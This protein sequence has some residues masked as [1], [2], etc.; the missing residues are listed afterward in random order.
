VLWFNAASRV[1]RDQASKVAAWG[2]NLELANVKAEDAWQVEA[3]RRPEWTNNGVA[4]KP[5]IRFDGFQSLVTEPIQLGSDQTSAVVFRV[6]GKSAQNLVHGRDEFKELGV[7]LLNL[8]GP[9]HTV[10]QINEDLR[11]EA[12]VHLGLLQNQPAPID[13]GRLRSST[14]IDDRPHV[15][16]YSFD[17]KN[18]VARLYLDGQLISESLDAPKIGPTNSPRYLGSHYD[19]RGF[20]FTGDS[21]EILVIDAA[22]SGE[23]SVKVSNWLAK[24]YNIGIPIVDFAQPPEN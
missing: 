13:I 23:E 3:S 12:R 15:A 5:S 18:S 16:L 8:N 19:R 14:A 21:A 22:L 7:Q 2:D 1:Q 9:P 17:T 20:G 6:D 11:L 4:G 10:L 24:K